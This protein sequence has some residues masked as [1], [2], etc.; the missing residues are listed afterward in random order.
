M[1]KK[2]YYPHGVV[3]RVGVVFTLVA[4]LLVVVPV[5]VVAVTEDVVVSRV[6]RLPVTLFVCLPPPPPTLGGNGCPRCSLAFKL[7]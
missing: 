6:C 7:K 3:L 5:M 4:P 1:K 2:W